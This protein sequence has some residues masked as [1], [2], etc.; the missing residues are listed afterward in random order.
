MWVNSNAINTDAQWRAFSLKKW[1]LI[2]PDELIFGITDL[3][4][5]F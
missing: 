5:A 2:D 4:Y 1:R 3:M